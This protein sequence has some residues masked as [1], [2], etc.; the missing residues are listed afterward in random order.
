M[1]TYLFSQFLNLLRSGLVVRHVAINVLCQGIHS[2]HLAQRPVLGFTG[3][4]IGL[5]RLLCSRLCLLL[6]FCDLSQYL[7]ILKK[8]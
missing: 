1:I 3:K 2:L 5:L 4:V 7:R 8:P 6:R